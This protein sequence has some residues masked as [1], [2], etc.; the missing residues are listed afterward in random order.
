MFLLWV[1]SCFFCQVACQ[2]NEWMNE[3]MTLPLGLYNQRR[4]E[5]RL[6]LSN[7]VHVIVWRAYICPVLMK[8]S[9]FNWMVIA[10]DMF[11]VI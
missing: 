2:I 1:H 5:K 4:L 6:Q 8:F 11:L 3:W 7:V 10:L 9:T